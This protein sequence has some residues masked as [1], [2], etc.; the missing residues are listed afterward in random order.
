MTVKDTVFQRLPLVTQ[1]SLQVR[2]VTILAGQPNSPICCTLSMITL[3]ADTSGQDDGKLGEHLI[4][5]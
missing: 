5:I 4:C 1:G 3:G 2:L